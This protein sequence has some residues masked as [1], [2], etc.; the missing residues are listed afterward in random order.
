MGETTHAQS[1]S[2]FEQA[3]APPVSRQIPPGTWLPVFI[4]QTPMLRLPLLA[5]VQWTSGLV[6]E[7]PQHSLSL[8]QRLFRILQPRPGWQT[9]T[10]VSA[11]GPQFRLQQLPQPSQSTPSCVQLPVPVVPTSMQTPWVAPEAIEQKPPQQSVLRAQTSP[12]WMQNEAPSTHLPPV[13]RPEQQSPAPLQ[14]LPAVAQVVL[15]GT[16][17]P[18]V[19]V[20]LQQPA[21]VVQAALSA[22]QLV[23]LAHL[24]VAVSHWRLQQSV[25]TAQELPAPL[26]VLT[27]D[28]QV[29]AT[30]SHDREQQ[31]L[32][33]VQAA[34]VTV[35][36]TPTPPASPAP[37]E[38]LD[39]PVPPAPVFTTLAELLPQLGSASSAAS[40]SAKMAMIERLVRDGRL[41]GV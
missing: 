38:P 19:Q 7:P 17:V 27:D 13:Q 1:L 18:P 12:G 30:G 25:L 36:V 15:S 6:P 41:M 31:S 21:E 35:Q 37:P 3:L 29:L 28:A 9:L 26:Q 16:H 32:L 34:P 10:P 22:T 11:Q 4:E 2:A 40:S 8:V 24:P 23:A 39:A 5:G 33:A 14:G 20:P